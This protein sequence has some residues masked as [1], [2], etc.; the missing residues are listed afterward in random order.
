MHGK[1]ADFGIVPVEN[2]VEGSVGD[3]L[4]MLLEWDLSISAECFERVEHSLLSLSGE[5]KEVKTVAS[6]SPGAWAVQEVG[7]REPLRRRAS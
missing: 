3:V 1:R 6:H 4:D 2:S 5:I 7:C